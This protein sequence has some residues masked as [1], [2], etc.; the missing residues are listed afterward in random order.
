MG[1]ASQMFGVLDASFSQS[2]FTFKKT[3]A[4]HEAPLGGPALAVFSLF[5]L[6]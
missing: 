4:S 5:A 1:Q 2:L 6:P 3:E